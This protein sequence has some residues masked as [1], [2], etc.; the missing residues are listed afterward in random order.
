[1]MST[2]AVVLTTLVAYKLVLVGIG[3]WARSRNRNEADFFLG[4]R[5]LGPWV[6]G[7]S[8]AA[9]TSSAWVILGFSGFV[10]AIGL[11]AL[12]MVPG[13]WAGYAVVWLYFGRRLREESLAHDQLTLTDFLLQD[14]APRQRAPVAA[15]A[16]AL[17]I[18]CFVFYIAAQFDA[19]GKALAEHFALSLAEAVALG[20]LIVAIYSMLGGYWAVSV[21]DTLQAIIMMLVAIGVPLAAL[22]AAGGAAAVLSALAEQMPPAYLQ[23]TGGHS[24]LVFIGFVVGVVGMSLGTFGQP[25]L[26][27]RLMAIRGERER[28]RGFAIVISWGVVV[29]LGMIALGLSGRALM[30][31]LANGEA[32]FYRTAT[33][34]L[35]AV[36]AG[37]VVAATL[38]AVMSTVDSILLAASGAVAHDLGVNRRFPE[39]QLLIS[40]AVTFAVAVLAVALTLSLPDTIFNRVLFAWS[41]LGAAFGPIVVWRVTGRLVPARAALACMLAGFSTTVLFYALGAAPETDSLLSQ[42]AH[43]PGD[44]FERAVPWLPSLIVLFF[45]TGRNHEEA[46]M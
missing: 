39:R 30:P 29:F 26:L 41:A 20:A 5:G 31:D 46:G 45:W 14:A 43:L 9:S 25:H 23:V 22:A 36:L 28:L 44:P 33:D 17:V 16:A 34:Y 11:S 18:G 38:S 7:L 1:M 35:P 8:Y 6:A 42:A 21:T 12:W 37:V 15:L 19:A 10:Y 24:A 13:I 27:S 40:R 32:L 4:G 2:S 3:L